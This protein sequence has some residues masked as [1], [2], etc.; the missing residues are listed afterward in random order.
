MCRGAGLS[1][2]AGVPGWGWGREGDCPVRLPW[3]SAAVAAE[4]WGKRVPTPDSVW[5]W[6][7]H[8]DLGLSDICPGLGIRIG[9]Q[10]CANDWVWEQ[11]RLELLKRG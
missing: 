10:Q 8:R 11:C 1:T 3:D 2:A 9:Q 5:E 7:A 6:D 4:D